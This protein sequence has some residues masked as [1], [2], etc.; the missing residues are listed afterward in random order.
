MT[1]KSK[2]LRVLSKN[3]R[4]FPTETEKFLWYYLRRKFPDIHFRRQ[5]PIG[6]YIVDFVAVKNKL[7]IECDGGQHTKENDKERDDFLKLQGYKVLRFWNPEIFNNTEGILTVIYTELF[8][9][10]KE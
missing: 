6:N 9:K 2:N 4:N 3:L 7:I 10:N 5:F 8:R 1:K